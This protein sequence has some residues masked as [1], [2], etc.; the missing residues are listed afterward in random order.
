MTEDTARA[1]AY[2]GPLQALGL[3]LGVLLLQVVIGGAIGVLGPR[4]GL[5]LPL[6]ASIGLANL[7]AFGVVIWWGVRASRLPAGRVLPFRAVG[8]A[9]YLALALTV[10]GLGIVASELDNLVRWALPVPRF[11]S[12][13]L[14]GIASGGAASLATIVVIAPV[15]EEMLF[16]GVILGGFADRYRPAT[17]VLTTAL[18]FGIVHLNPYQ[19]VSALILGVVLGWVFLKTRSLWPCIFAHALFNGHA[20]A[21]AAL[22][23]FEIPGY[24]P[25]EVDLRVVEFQPLWFD[26]LGLA[27]A[28]IGLAA[29]V[30]LFGRERAGA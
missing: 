19:F 12:D 6:A 26:V 30:R 18:V 1:Q 13:M 20:F 5:G 4:M 23:P 3:V 17:A 28:A 8:P 14:I 2:P 29:L 11:L 25:A 7:C 22:V 21:L 9:V 24:N 27:A 10:L 15:V 16:R